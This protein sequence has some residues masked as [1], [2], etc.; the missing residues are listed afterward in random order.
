MTITITTKDVRRAYEAASGPEAVQMFWDD[1]RS[2]EISLQDVGILGRWHNE[3]DD[4]GVPFRIAP[5]A[6]RCGLI[7]QQQAVDVFANAELF[8]TPREIADMAQA[9]AWMIREGESADSRLLSEV[10]RSKATGQS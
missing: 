5:A 10:P 6:W 9:D 3:P 1:L 7:T 4:E 8:F 2:G